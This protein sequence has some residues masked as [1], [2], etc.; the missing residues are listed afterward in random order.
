MKLYTLGLVVL[1][2][3]MA[4]W[5]LT[6]H[7]EPPI[8]AKPSETVLEPKYYTHPKYWLP[9]RYDMLMQKLV[10]NHPLAAPGMPTSMGLES[11]TI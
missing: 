7:Y 5:T 11:S 4:K 8:D 6:E 2:F 10:E 3:L 9:K 1:A